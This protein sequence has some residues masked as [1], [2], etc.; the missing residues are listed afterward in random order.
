MI[1]C[2]LAALHHQAM[3]ETEKSNCKP[4][5]ILLIVADDLSPENLG[6]YGGER[7]PTPNLDRLSSMG[8]TFENAWTTPMCMPSRAQ[9]LTGSNA[10]RT[11]LWHNQLTVRS[12]GRN[13]FEF[14]RFH[15]TI[16]KLLTEVGYRTALAGKAHAI[17]TGIA[18]TPNLNP[19]KAGYDQWSIYDSS[20]ILS[21]ARNWEAEHTPPGFR[22][23]VASRYW[24]PS[25]FENGKP[26]LTEPDEF[27][28]D[29][30]ADFLLEFMEDSARSG[31]PSLSIFMM[32]LPHTVAGGRPNMPV[33]PAE[34][35]PGNNR[36]G[37]FEGCVAYI[38]VIVGRIVDRLEETGV[39]ENTIVIF[40]SDNADQGFGKT[41]VVEQGARVPMFIIGPER[42][43]PEP[44]RSRSLVSL[45]DLLPT[46]ADWAGA[47]VPT[48]EE[49]DGVNLGPYLRGESSAPRTW[50][51][52]YA[53]TAAVIRDAEWVLE[54]Y[55]PIGGHEGRLY[56][57]ENHYGNIL[58]S[59]RQKFPNDTD[60]ED[61]IEARARLVD[62][63]RKIHVF[64]I[65]NANVRAALERYQKA[66]YPHRLH[67]VSPR[68][69][70]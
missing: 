5:N 29:L 60:D 2:S 53:G 9:I 47:R 52:S 23:P 39:L 65:E 45:A 68:R 51:Y 54:A 16:P 49:I 19:S 13:P 6:H 7:I 40:V 28:D 30:F 27:S 64:D 41:V 50:L 20:G 61:A 42:Y 62:I 59:Y 70:P 63:L 24:Q 66:A 48:L 17:G 26:R 37:T 55:D 10:T 31:Q 15:P 3:S 35:D 21:E 57:Y 43:I 22:G 12:D 69:N 32:I 33:T 67:E 44:R 14:A 58:E 18:G 11:G 25:I 4:P 8:I 56:R 36:D 34:G 1:T 38:D 46:F